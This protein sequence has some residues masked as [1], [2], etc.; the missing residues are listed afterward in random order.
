MKARYSGW[1][2]PARVVR[3]AWVEDLNLRAAFCEVESV[4]HTVVPPGVSIGRAE[5]S[6]CVCGRNNFS[7]SE[8]MSLKLFD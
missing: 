6:Q 7:L 2:E 5:Y 1:V 4:V 8:N 3:T